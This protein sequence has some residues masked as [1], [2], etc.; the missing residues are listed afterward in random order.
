MVLFGMP[1]FFTLPLRLVPHTTLDVALTD[2]PTH[3]DFRVGQH[4]VDMT[5]QRTPPEGDNGTVL[6][7]L[8]IDGIERAQAEAYYDYDMWQDDAPVR[9]SWLHFDDD[10]ARDLKINLNYH[11]ETIWIISSAQGRL[12]NI[13]PVLE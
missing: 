1:A 8:S 9:Y 12:Y 11:L 2:E 3:Y 7:I 6:V 5:L 10:S 13:T 4:R